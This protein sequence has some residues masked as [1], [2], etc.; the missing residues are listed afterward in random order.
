MLFYRRTRLAI[1]KFSEVS[2][3]SEL[4]LYFCVVAHCSLPAAMA[5]RSRQRCC[6]CSFSFTQRRVLCAAIFF[7]LGVLLA[8]MG[9]L[10]IGIFFP[11]AVDNKI[12][13][14]ADIWD[15]GSFGGKAFVGYGKKELINFIYK[16]LLSIYKIELLIT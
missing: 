14:W 8:L 6:S 2:R 9:G 3:F 1:M 15:M 7:A 5:A 16:C 13:A 11:K 12:R 4:R 10:C